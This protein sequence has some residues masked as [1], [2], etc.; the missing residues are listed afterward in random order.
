MSSEALIGKEQAHPLAKKRWILLLSISILLIVSCIYGLLVGSVSFTLQDI[1]QGIMSEEDTMARRIIWDL[2]I[3]RVIVGLLVGMCLAVAGALMQGVMQNPLADPGIIGVSS[4]AGL[5]ATII[6]ILF[7]AYMIFV[8]LAAFLGAFVTAMVVYGLAWKNGASPARI[9]L[10]GISINALIG[11]T[12]STIMLLHSDK[13]QSVLPW[14]AGGVAGVSWAHVEMISYY[15]IGALVL[16]LFGIKHVRLLSLGDEVA[17]LLGHNVERS[18]FFLIVL[19]TLLAGIAVSVAGLVGF[20]GLVIPHMV[21][22]LIG[23]DY[24]Y[25]LPISALGGG[26]LVVLTDTI[27]RSAFDPIELPVGLL[28]SFIGG[29]FFLFLIQRGGKGRAIS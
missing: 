15:A 26:F 8:P 23:N 11:A 9:I 6:M 16:S 13:V 4:G 21:R 17:T 3:P 1:Y 25:L 24:R 22:L 12:M 18:R 2:R 29:P 14:L 19:S 5:M 28:L 20:V 10:V 27:A 7:P